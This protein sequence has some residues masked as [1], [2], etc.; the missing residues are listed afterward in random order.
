MYMCIAKR[1]KTH[2]NVHN[3]YFNDNFRGDDY[4]CSSL[5]TLVYIYLYIQDIGPLWYVYNISHLCI[6]V[7]LYM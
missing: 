6:Y 2:W 5:Y 3:D 1:L 4:K 7:K